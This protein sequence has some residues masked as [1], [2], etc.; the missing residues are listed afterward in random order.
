MIPIESP[1]GL[2][3]KGVIVLLN[4]LPRTTAIAF[5]IRLAL[6]PFSSS[7]GIIYLI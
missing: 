5:E 2:E 3:L 4:L 1:T 6:T 7:R